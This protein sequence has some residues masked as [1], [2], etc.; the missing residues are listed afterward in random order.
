MLKKK[1]IDTKDLLEFM[2]HRGPMMWIDTVTG[3]YAEGGSIKLTLDASKPY[4][5]T[6]K[7]S[8]TFY[9]EFLAQ[10]YGYVKA[11]YFVSQQDDSV[12]KLDKAL[13]PMI[14]SYK[15]VEGHELEAGEIVTGEIETVKDM[16]PLFIIQGKAKNSNGDVMATARF[17]VFAIA[18]ELV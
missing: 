7:L 2:P 4:F 3:Y 16:Y 15:V 8:K 5:S 14:D 11:A 17:K 9:L 13:I 6:G 12:G 18:E 10:G 1:D